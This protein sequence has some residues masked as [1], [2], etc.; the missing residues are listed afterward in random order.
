MW[1]TS[2][3]TFVYTDNEYVAYEE[4]DYTAINVPWLS[5]I[6]TNV[7]V[8]RGY[9]A[10]RLFV[11]DDEAR[12]SPAQFGTPGVD[13]GGGD[14]KYKDLNGDGKITDLDLAPIGNPTVPRITYGFGLS[15]GWKDFDIS[16]FFQGLGQVSFLINPWTTGPF[17]N[18]FGAPITGQN[19]I[20]ISQTGLGNGIRSENG[21]LKAYADDHW[22]EENRNV[23]ALW[24]RLS[25]QL[26]QNNG[27]NSTFWLRNGSFIRLKQA[28]I[29]YDLAN[30]VL[31]NSGIKRCRLYVNGT[32][33]FT[34]SAF[35]LWD[36]ELKGNGLNYPLQRVFNIGLNVGF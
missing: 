24:P 18:T 20:P 17:I 19:I 8:V 12:N 27:Q 28:E 13:Y 16:F 3:A 15:G 31:K 34:W 1:L 25:T 21:L 32:N 7:N 26:I 23:Y 36:P 11:D 4:P 6:G 10:E 33:L 35:K 22:S 2:R 14:I 30:T 5:R 29:G 9:I